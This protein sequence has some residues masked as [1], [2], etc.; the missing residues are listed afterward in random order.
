METTREPKWTKEQL[1]AINTRGCNLLV[2]AGAGAGKTAVLVQRIINM[3]TNEDVKTDIDKL[4]IVT[5]TNA[6]A[7]EMRER[8]GIAVSKELHK[9]P[10]SKSLQRQLTLLNK[11]SITTIHSFCLE[12]IKN[13]FRCIDLDP[14]FRIGDETEIML[15]K[16]D[17]LEEIFEGKYEE[18][19]NEFLKLV[20]AYGGNHDDK[21]LQDLVL[22]LYNFSMSS[23]EPEKWINESVEN[24]NIND[25]FNFK[26]TKWAKV[27]MEDIEIELSGIESTIK[28]AIITA[29][30][31]KGLE[32]YAINFKDDLANIEFI[33][34]G[35]GKFS[36]LKRLKKDSNYDEELQDKLKKIREDYKKKIKALGEDINSLEDNQALCDL[37]NLYPLMKSLGNLIIDFKRKFSVRKKDKGI[38]DFNDIEHFCLN[39]LN[40]ND[41]V[42][43]E[44][45]NKYEEVLVDEYQDSN[46]VQEAIL[47]KVSRK[48]PIPNLFMVGDVKQ[49]IYRFRQAKPEL[50]LQKYNTY[51]EEEGADNRKV[52]L[53][54]NF[55]SRKEIIDGVNFIFKS[56][57]S[58]NIGEIDYNDKEKL[59][60]GANY[61]ELHH[62]NEIELH[63]IESENEVELDEVEEDEEDAP[64]KVQIEARLIGKRIKELMKQNENLSFKDIVVLMR[65]PSNWAEVFIEEFKNIG[66]PV[67]ADT[68]TGYFKSVEVSTVLSLLQIIDN[69]IQDI[70][71]LAVL[72]SPIAFFT[73]EELGQIRLK[74]SNASIYNCMI[75]IKDEEG[76][77]KNKITW[78]LDKLN[79]WREKSLFTPI[80]EFIWY[81]YKDTGFYGYVGAMPGGAQRQANLRLLF[82]KAGVFE[83]TVYKGLFNFINFINRLKITSGDMGEAKVLGENENVVRIMSIHKS[84]GLE[85]PV[86]FL[87]GCGKNFNLSDINRK[88]LYHHTLGLGPEY[89]DVERRIT[90]TT[91]FKEAIKKKILLE[92]LSEEMRILYVAF[93]RAKEK[94]I[95]TGSVKNLKKAVSTWSEGL[96]EYNLMKAKNYLDWIAPAI[97]Q[98]EQGEPLR[99]LD[100]TSFP[101]E[102]LE[103]ESKW[104][105]M[106][107]KGKD[108]LTDEHKN[109]ETDE[110]QC[111]HSD[112]TE[113][114]N[115]RL[116]Y[117]YPF[118]AS[119]NL[120][121][122]ISVTELKRSLTD[123]EDVSAQLFTA[124]LKKPRFIEEQKGLTATEKGT[125][126]HYVMQQIRLKKEDMSLHY[127]K[128]EI[129]RL[130][131]EQ[132]I[133]KEWA[134][135]VNPYKICNFFKSNLGQRILKSNKV[136][137]EIPFYLQLSARE[138]YKNLQDEYKDENIIVQGI[139]DCY[140]EEDD[141]IILLDYKTDYAT[142]ENIEELINKYKIQ[143][144][145]YK[146]VLQKII[147]KPVKEKYIYFFGL[148]KEVSI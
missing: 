110:M 92:S 10:D 75:K 29:E 82:Q 37:K 127:I 9:N 144:E 46:L 6:A 76:E 124:S 59:N 79:Y 1:S 2:S 108:V 141:G 51:S 39:I 114:I 38:I 84:K 94:L 15:L 31:A 128:E 130:L 129:N 23:P 26:N 121:N 147:E 67:Y 61:E 117:I 49:S 93:T 64:D 35:E 53:Y 88:M 78:L 132:F 103:D 83:K 21:N 52:L 58:E 43:K 115:R 126:T 109:E 105:V 25:D 77:L 32:P 123:E 63:I 107:W 125:A 22:A 95:I 33:L 56:I 27:L 134:D 133:T 57:M 85:F 146:T 86:V 34:K 131:V 73:S 106:L 41:E 135:G 112:C 54:K 101:E 20:E 48:E 102:Y 40:E 7:S 13:N 69:P 81:L 137:R 138:I 96:G 24:F 28:N 118:I 42:V 98:H 119:S 12:V 87:A 142:E 30:K 8:I 17:A 11:A 97:M 139:V 18:E 60:M 145:Y 113:E 100:A 5:F 50:F 122:K 71:M 65:S 47:Q 74:D 45:R 66:I 68:N 19:D 140:F 3:I 111:C 104:K 148:D 14:N 99:S 16:T 136:K 72:R 36:T 70:P 44:L 62:E 143:L 91:I 120:P 55:R 116:N 80:D 90:H 4:L 89:V